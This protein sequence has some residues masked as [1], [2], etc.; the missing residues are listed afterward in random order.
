MNLLDLYAK[1]TLDTN[2]YEKG[3]DSASG[4][5]SGLASKLKNG[6]ATAA[7]V[8][9]A[10]V[11]AAATGIAALAKSSI[12]Q[13]AEYEQLVG[14]VDT[15]FK[16]ASDK[17]QEYAE[18]AYRTAGLSA[19][20]YMDTV[21]SFSASLIQSLE[22]DTEQ[23]AEKANVAITDMADNANKMGTSMEMIQNAYN[24]FAKQN[25]TMLD[26]LK[27]GY[28]GTKE[29]MQRLIEHASSLTDIQAELGVTVDSSSMS[30]SNIVDAIHVVQKEMGIMGAT[31]AEAAETI[32]GSIGMMKGAWK[33]FI[34]GLSDTTADHGRLMGDLVDSVK[35]VGKN[36]GPVIKRLIPAV[37]DGVG[38][39]ITA[40]SEQIPEMLTAAVGSIPSLIDAAYVIIQNLYGALISAL[41]AIADAGAKIVKRLAT[42]LLGISP[43]VVDAGG[44]IAENLLGAFR[45]AVGSVGAIAGALWENVSPVITWIADGFRSWVDSVDWEAFQE[46]ID[47]FV[48]LISENGDLILAVITGI[49]TGFIAWNVATMI[50]GVIAAIK[51][52]N[53]VTAIAE[54]KQRALNLA[55]NTNP[56][57]LIISLV[58]GLVTAIVTFIATNEDARNAVIEIWEKIKNAFADAWEAIKN[59]FSRW[60]E[61]F[62]GLWDQL[63]DIFSGVWEWFTGIGED[64]V[65]GIWQGISNVWDSLVGWFNNLWDGLFGGRSVDVSVNQSTNARVD[66]SHAGGLRSV[67][68]DGYIA[69]LHKG[70]RVLTAREASR[71]NNRQ[72][73]GG[74]IHITVQS[75]L[76]GRVIGESTYKYIRNRGRALGV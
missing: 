42:S 67:P 23:A 40:V 43:E 74:P 39:L 53:I 10:A 61:F 5:A 57:M 1:I 27:L 58:V 52:F 14:G 70:E 2:E 29:E 25:Y 62:S 64:I 69:E 45:K 48:S 72:T 76:D 13:Y 46:K 51:G 8:G 18:N 68:F 24:G 34:T 73:D 65:N 54:I 11:G 17:V 56:I 30:F 36:I 66:G 75:V 55:M 28:G 49:G 26:N 15:L 33:N 60:G 63:T 31:E 41:P 4:K 9:A 16:T 50:Q 19:N 35:T 12:D 22:G 32:S 37:A 59:T 44:V 3:L 38:G 71:Y 21:T 7:K 47:S 20:E 6:L